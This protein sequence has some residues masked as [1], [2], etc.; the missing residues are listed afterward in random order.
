M[1]HSANHHNQ[2]SLK[3]NLWS[4]RLGFK[5]FV[6]SRPSRIVT[7]WV[8]SLLFKTATPTCRPDLLTQAKSNTTKAKFNN[9]LKK[10][11]FSSI[12]LLVDRFQASL[13]REPLHKSTNSKQLS[14]TLKFSNLNSSLQHPR[15]LILS[16]ANRWTL[17][18]HLNSS[19]FNSL[20][21][22]RSF[23]QSFSQFNSL[24]SSHSKPYNQHH[25]SLLN[26]S[27][28][29]WRNSL[30]TKQWCLSMISQECKQAQSQW[31]L[32]WT[33]VPTINRLR[34]RM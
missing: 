28:R 30:R 21:R 22:S 4:R 29:M 18:S 6:R 11:G 23:N 19:P 15:D 34:S 1:V 16:P 20:S 10:W 26:L 2:L 31:G 32:L 8:I 3:T 12:L 24:S 7:V 17:S 13:S 27:P 9:S 25:I 33:Q 14:R 5:W